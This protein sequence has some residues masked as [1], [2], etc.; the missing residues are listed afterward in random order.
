MKGVI[1]IKCTN[2]NSENVELEDEFN[3]GK[4][5]I[6]KVICLDCGFDKNPKVFTRPPGVHGAMVI[7]E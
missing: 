5:R 4:G 2:C 6:Q 1:M 7:D 3:S